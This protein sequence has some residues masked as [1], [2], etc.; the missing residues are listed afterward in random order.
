MARVSKFNTFRSRFVL[1]YGSAAFI[2]ILMLA[3]AG[4]IIYNITNTYSTLSTIIEPFKFN[5]LTFNS[6]AN[7]L[8]AHQLLLYEFTLLFTTACLNLF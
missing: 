6:E 1:I 2:S 4:G 3:A 5:L 8:A 7:Q